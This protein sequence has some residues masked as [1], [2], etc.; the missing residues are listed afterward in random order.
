MSFSLCKEQ[1]TNLHG[2]SRSIKAEKEIATAEIA[3]KLEIVRMQFAL[4]IGHYLA[5]PSDKTVTRFQVHLPTLSPLVS[6]RNHSFDPPTS[7]KTSG[8]ELLYNGTKNVLQT[9]IKHLANAFILS[10]F[11]LQLLPPQEQLPRPFARQPCARRLAWAR[12]GLTVSNSILG[13]RPRKAAV[14]KAHTSTTHTAHLRTHVPAQASLMA[15][16]KCSKLA[17]K[18]P[19]R[20][21]VC[22]SK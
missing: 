16:S 18:G 15:S 13:G 9:V 1:W 14:T 19:S 6:L 22:F 3:H 8:S 4:A 7:G 5:C 11:K 2:T 20:V 10:R 17:S 21:C 12:L